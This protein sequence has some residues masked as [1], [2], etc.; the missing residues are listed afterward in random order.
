[1]V[2]DAI[3]L[4]PWDGPEID[5]L[6]LETFDLGV[7][8]PA[9]GGRRVGAI[10]CVIGE[11]ADGVLVETFGPSRVA[12]GYDVE[13]DARGIV[14]MPAIANLAPVAFTAAWSTSGGTV[15]DAASAGPD[16]YR[17]AATIL[18][19]NAQGRKLAGLA[20][21]AA[22][23]RHVQWFARSDT[24]HSARV[25]L[26]DATGATVEVRD[27]AVTT[28][29]AAYSYSY[30]TW[31]GATAGVGGLL[32][33]GS[34]TASEQTIYLCPVLC[35]ATVRPPAG[36]IP[37]GS[38]GTTAPI[39]DVSTLT[40]RANRE[41]E[42]AVE[43]Y[44]GALVTSATLATLRNADNGNDQREVRW[45]YGAGDIV[46]GHATGAGVNVDAAA[47]AV[48][49]DTSVP[50]VGKARWNRAGLVDGVASEWSSI[51]G[52]QG[53]VVA[54]ASGRGAT[55]AASTAPPT[56]LDIGHDNGADVL[57]GLVF[58]ASVKTREP[59]L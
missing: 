11:N 33:C 31:A 53:A 54:T 41:G 22:G 2:L 18:G 1:V 59:K 44:L 34:N 47:N 21:G 24:A 52:E 46:G 13:S 38:P 42:L 57:P 49:L 58:S 17:T 6:N 51:R 30:T 16:G 48:A 23:T 29:W 25:I 12:I 32:F 39:V 8:L 27:Y 15:T 20:L 9:G 4:W 55:W 5:G 43:A 19:T 36:V 14:T 50:I 40:E 56:R 35:V 28:L 45:D 3:D 26:Q 10:A 7:G 37:I